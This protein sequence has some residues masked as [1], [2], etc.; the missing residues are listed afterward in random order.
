[1]PV[2][3]TYPGV[4]IQELPSSVH[5]I[6][7]VPTSVAAFVGSA[8]RGVV[9]T[10]V[11]VNSFADYERSFGGLDPTSP[12]SY[13]VFLFFLNGGNIAQIVRAG[14]APPRPAANPNPAG[15][16]APAN[17]NP[18]DPP[19]VDPIP[20]PA[21][22][23][24]RIGL[25][26]NQDDQLVLVATSE[27]EWGNHLVVA[28]DNQN[29]FPAD[30]ANPAAPPRFNLTITDAA[31]NAVERYTNLTVAPGPNEISRALAQSALMTVDETSTPKT[32][33]KLPDPKSPDKPITFVVPPEK[34]AGALPLAPEELANKNGSR[35]VDIGTVDVP[36]DEG[37]RSGIYALVE[38]DIFNMLCLPT[39]PKATYSSDDLDRAASFC[40][41][42]RAM[43]IV[44]PP[45]AWSKEQ[46]LTFEKAVGQPALT[47]DRENA[48]VYYPNLLVADPVTKSTLQLGPCGAVAGLWA[49]TDDA[50]GVWKAPAGTTA[51]IGGIRDLAAHV[52]DPESGVLNPIA[53]NALRSIP[54]VG[55]VAWGARTAD[56]ADVL[57]S[58]WK[59]IPV[60][61]TALFIEESLRRGTQW[62]VFEPNDEPLWSAIRLN[63]GSFM[64]SLFK[65]GAFQGST[66]SDAYLVKCDAGNNPQSS[67][68]QGVVNILVGFQPLLP[69]EFVIIS[70]QQLVGQL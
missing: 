48:A 62:V 23:S 54:L 61:R 26:D 30:P 2:T 58:Q 52:G 42:Q 18:G 21:P 24:A 31:S 8:P 9:N 20:G 67:I 49:A 4:Y 37:L 50:R 7:G 66:P 11:Q 63:V 60:R 43:L 17:Q 12:M 3:P 51:T 59:Y 56:G 14:A 32:L 16:A 15:G 45:D 22:A 27:G 1:L 29:V 10:P 40:V 25:V 44:D 57:G 6:V 46:L 65:Q 68:N 35:G 28:V 70:I 5:T 55:P 69:A 36:G 38:A 33:P 34:P 64:N 53:V 47:K 41:K 13:A 39:H 19:P